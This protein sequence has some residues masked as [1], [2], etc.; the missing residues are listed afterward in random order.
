MY[1]YL[2]SVYI[3]KYLTIIWRAYC[4]S[5]IVPNAFYKLI[6]LFLITLLEVV[7][8]TRLSHKVVATLARARPV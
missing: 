5:G 7:L 3:Y 6:H 2:Y 8:Y 1:I 4:E